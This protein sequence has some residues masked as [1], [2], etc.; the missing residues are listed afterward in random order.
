MPASNLSGCRC[1]YR[2]RC[3]YSSWLSRFRGRQHHILGFNRGLLCTTRRWSE[4]RRASG[5]RLPGRRHFGKHRKTQMCC[6][7][8]LSQNYRGTGA[9]WETPRHNC[10]WSRPEMPLF[11]ENGRSASLRNRIPRLKRS[12]CSS[13]CSL[14]KGKMVSDNGEMGSLDEERVCHTFYP[15]SFSLLT[16]TSSVAA[17]A[18][19]V[20]IGLVLSAETFSKAGRYGLVNFWGNSTIS[21]LNLLFQSTFARTNCFWSGQIWSEGHHSGWFPHRL[22]LFDYPWAFTVPRPSCVGS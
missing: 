3:S 17:L 4:K 12:Q 21:L 19:M 18:D 13:W 6:G 22:E 1:P 9:I 15:T 2:L 8:A 14:P 10:S 5:A 16:R 7:R 20:A 11:L